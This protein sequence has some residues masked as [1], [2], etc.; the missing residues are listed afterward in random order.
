[1]EL[2]YEIFQ[3]NFEIFNKELLNRLAK[4]G[5]LLPIS[6]YALKGEKIRDWEDEIR[7]SWIN[8]RIVKPNSRNPGNLLLYKCSL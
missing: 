3:C 8:K 7:T 4:Y 5:V 2:Y 6:V 1:M